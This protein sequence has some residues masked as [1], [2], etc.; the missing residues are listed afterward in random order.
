MPNLVSVK[1]IFSQTHTALAGSRLYFH[2]SRSNLFA[3][4]SDS[5]FR[6]IMAPSTAPRSAYPR[7][8]P[9][10]NR[11]N[12]GVCD[13]LSPAQVGF[14]AHDFALP[15]VRTYPETSQTN[16][17]PT[18]FHCCHLAPPNADARP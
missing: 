8:S 5:E 6:R 16:N 14:M 9:P 13:W 18:I 3:D 11:G 2:P 10:D 15:R 1:F 4:A 17:A 7:I 12:I